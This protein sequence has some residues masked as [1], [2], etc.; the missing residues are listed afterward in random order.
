[1]W[2]I[3]L[4]MTFIP[5]GTDNNC[6]CVSELQLSEEAPLGCLFST[7]MRNNHTWYTAR[8][9]IPETVCVSVRAG[10][11]VCDYPCCYQQQSSIQS[12]WN[13]RFSFVTKQFLC[14]HGAMILSKSQRK[15]RGGEK[16]KSM[17]PPIISCRL[18][19]AG[20]S[21]VSTHASTFFFSLLETKKNK[22]KKPPPQNI[23][24]TLV[25]ICPKCLSDI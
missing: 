6:D 15:Q 3:A 12:N 2:A 23:T 19:V 14:F 25:F 10:E 24:I 11:S 7:I 13:E 16:E 8:F 21:H 18:N 5:A 17:S 20:H 4:E 9:L 22:Q 1:M